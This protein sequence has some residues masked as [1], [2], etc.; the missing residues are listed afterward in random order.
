[1]YFYG[2]GAGLEKA[3]DG[4]IPVLCVIFWERH[5]YGDSERISGYRGGAGRRV[6]AGGPG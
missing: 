2:R 5:K 4:V 3:T 1:M 6:C